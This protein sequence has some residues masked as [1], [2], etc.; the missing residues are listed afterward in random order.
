MPLVPEQVL[1]NRYRIVKL[2][3]HGGFGAV[4]QAWDVNLSRA[5]AVKENLNIQPEAQRQFTREAT[6]LAN[7]SHP[8]LPRVTDYFIIEG[9]GQYLVMDFV[10]GEDLATIVGRQGPVPATQAVDWISQVLD[11]LVYLHSRQPPVVHRDI[12]PANIRITPEGKAVLVDFGLVKIYDPGMHTSLGA[13]A[14][15]PGY[16]PPEQYGRGSTDPRTDIYALGSTLYNL[17]TGVDPMDSIRRMVGKEF[18]TAIQVNPQVPVA[19]SQVVER[20]MAIEAAQRFQTAAE[21]KAAL[22]QRPAAEF[23]R[24]PFE[25][26]APVP[27]TQRMAV[28][29]PSEVVRPQPSSRAQEWAPQPPGRPQPGYAPPVAPRKQSGSP[30]AARSRTGLLVGGGL[31][32]LA[33][34]VVAGIIMAWLSRQSDLSLWTEATVTPTLPGEQKVL[35]GPANGSLSHNPANQ[36][37]E[38]FGTGVNVRDFIAEVQ[39]LNPYAA[40]DGSWDYGLVFRHEGENRHFRLLL[41]SDSTYVFL[42]HTGDAQGVVVQQGKIDTLNLGS[43]GMNKVRLVCDEQKGWL[44]VNDVFISELNL[45]FRMNPG[46]LFVVT[47]VYQ[48]DEM[49]GK[50]TGYQG[51]TVWPA[52]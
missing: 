17:L 39:F 27:A 26:P 45:S 22:M 40:S 52:P 12:K 46:N 31:A 10:E 1:N 49:A 28:P 29:P 30:E 21:F 19:T 33:C 41:L 6:I 43:G 3:G 47:G 4:F 24:P 32:L 8:N 14:V 23:V 36:T 35:F 50:A 5:C 7:L 2:L 25:A 34:L 15:T 13:R 42:N 51:L 18:A 11:A 37:I 20:A 38:G 16:A 9:Q 48:G 44:Y